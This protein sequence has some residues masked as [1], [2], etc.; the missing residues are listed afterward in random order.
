MNGNLNVECFNL[1]IF[2][3]IINNNELVR[4]QLTSKI[5]FEMA[6][7]SCRILKKERTPLNGIYLGQRESDNDNRMITTRN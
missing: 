1:F 4:F 7:D 6:S 5:V 3:N 2:N